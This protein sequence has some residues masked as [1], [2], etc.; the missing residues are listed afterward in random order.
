MMKLVQSLFF[1]IKYFILI[2]LVINLFLIFILFFRNE[3]SSLLF[4]NSLLTVTLI[5]LTIL[6][7]KISEKK[8]GG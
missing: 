1:T 3:I 8:R 6:F 4:L 2:L 5:V 7:L